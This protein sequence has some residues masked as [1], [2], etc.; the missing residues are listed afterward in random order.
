[1]SALF[2]TSKGSIPLPAFL[3]VTTF[4]GKHP[5]DDLVRHYLNRLSPAIMV[6]RYYAENMEPQP[7]PVFIDSG[8]FASLFEGSQV[9]H[10]PDGT[11]GIQ[12]REGS[13]V[14]PASVLE[15]QEK[16]AEIGATL[17]F[18]IPPKSSPEERKKLQDWTIQNAKWAFKNRTRKDFYLFA[19]L[20]AWDQRSME[21]TLRPL[22][23]IP[24]DGF[25]LGGMV[26]RIRTPNVIFEL[27]KAFR[28]REPTRPLHIF[29]VGAPSL[30]KALFEHGVNS[31]DSSNYV[32]QA[33]SKRYFLPAKGTYVELNGRISPSNECSCPVCQQFSQDYLSLE[34]ELNKMA[35]ALHNLAATIA[36]LE[37]D[38][39]HGT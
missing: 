17:D 6:S 27:V 37:I 29:G 35:L 30:V 19:S 2:E 24:F 33:A 28:K 39:A 11:H 7:C 5:L 38:K 26:P 4:G 12:S 13:L 36:Y 1:M 3:P 25:A 14:T 10:L 8:G 32:R 34:G 16:R 20:Q 15:L 18:I 31:V 9:V 23:E 22:Q 21:R